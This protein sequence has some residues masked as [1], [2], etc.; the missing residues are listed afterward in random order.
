MTRTTARLALLAAAVSAAPV[1]TLAAPTAQVPAVNPASPAN[2]YHSYRYQIRWR[3]GSA[4]IA[5][6]A[7]LA[8]AASPAAAA[9]A[10]GRIKGVQKTTD[11]TLERGVTS[12]S[13]FSAW[14]NAKSPNALESLTVDVADEAGRIASS[15][16][17]AKCHAVEVQALPDLDAGGNAMQIAHL[18]LRCGP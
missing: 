6:F 16:T 4:P 5:G 9:P 15:K 10:P 13:D 1:S 11:V 2:R 14:L 8:E 12:A 18:V 3:G 17:H 7:K